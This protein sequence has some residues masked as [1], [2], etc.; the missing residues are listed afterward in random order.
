MNAPA[1]AASPPVE[2][3]TAGILWM[4]ATMACFVTLDTTMKA[5]LT[6]YSLVQVTWG[7]FF[8]AALFTLILCGRDL[9]RLLRSHAPRLQLARSVFQTMTTFTFNTGLARVPLA[10]ASIIMFLAPVLVTL[11]S[12]PVLGERVSL[13]RWIAIAVAFLGAAIVMEPW[14][15]G[16]LGS[17]FGMIAILAAA[18]FNASYQITT[19]QLRHD[20]P[21]TSLLFTV[22]F[23]ALVTSLMLPWFWQWP[24]L[25]GWLM[26][27]A[28]GALGTLGHLF[29][30]RAF[31][32]APASVVAPF[33]YSTLIWAALLGWLVFGDWPRPFTWIGA[34]L[35][36]G[37]GLYNFLDIRQAARPKRAGNEP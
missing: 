34:T 25:K 4:L 18:L 15:A 7:R 37:S 19:R 28:S 29:I 1:P 6:R 3:R 33:S 26:L 2:N 5:E 36:I 31:R 11:L 27:M 23:G 8:F 10:T 30:I 32:A 21:L 17:G 16:G 14:S 24:D 13:R 12:I 20:D 35:I 22:A 9:P